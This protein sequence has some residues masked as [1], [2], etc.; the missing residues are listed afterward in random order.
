MQR[1]NAVALLGVCLIAAASATIVIDN[2]SFTGDEGVV[3]TSESTTC[4]TCATCESCVTCETCATG[5][6]CEPTFKSIRGR[7]WSTG[8]FTWRVIDSLTQGMS[9]AVPM[10]EQTATEGGAL[11]GIFQLTNLD[12]GLATTQEFV[13][14]NPADGTLAPA[15]LEFVE[16]LV[17]AVGPELG[18]VYTQLFT[19]LQVTQIHGFKLDNV[20]FSDDFTALSFIADFKITAGGQ[21]TYASTLLGEQ[22]A[23]LL[24]QA[25][26]QT[27]WL[28]D[29][30]AAV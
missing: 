14:R 25:Y 17:A 7:T 26:Q 3:F 23:L 29:P 11:F 22:A 20:Q 4:E 15:G 5:E 24:Q 28:V 19:D 27:P 1:I 9:S 13:F 18:A 16:Q 21:V 6:T 30:P 8:P 2:N 12:N 10:L